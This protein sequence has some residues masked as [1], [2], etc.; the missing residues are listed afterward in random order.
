MSITYKNNLGNMISEKQALWLS[1]YRKVH[2]VNGVVKQEEEFFKGNFVRLY[3]YKD[4]NETHQ[5]IMAN[6]FISGKLITIIERET[7]ASVYTLEKSFNY[8]ANGNLA[9]K[10]NRVFDANNDLI[11]HEEIWDLNSNVPKYELTKKYYYDRN[12]NPEK[13]LF[14]C[15]YKDNGTL[16]L[17]YYNNEHF[18]PDEQDSEVF[19]DSP[20]DIQTLRDLTGIS[21]DLADYYVSSEVIP[22]F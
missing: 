10:G 11:A 19:D 7:V 2:N 3:Y 22:N 5:Q 17:L 6:F 18:N 21:Q 9:G 4:Q 16:G 20:Q 15:S 8:N 14:E 12:I 13:Y 1:E